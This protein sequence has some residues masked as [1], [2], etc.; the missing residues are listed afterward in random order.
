MTHLNVCCLIGRGRVRA[1]LCD[2]RAPDDSDENLLT[3]ESLALMLHK[4]SIRPPFWVIAGAETRQGEVKRRKL[5]S[6][7]RT[8]A[9]QSEPLHALFEQP[10]KLRVNF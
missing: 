2:L 4:V 1:H 5:S 9:D 10:S 6:S 8:A 7:V 3:T